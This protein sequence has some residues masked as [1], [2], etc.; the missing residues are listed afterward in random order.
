[1]SRYSV[2]RK[3]K[4]TFTDYKCKSCGEENP[5]NFYGRK[6]TECKN[7]F[8]RRSVER[9]QSHKNRAV[10]L[11]GGKCSNC[12]YNT[13]IGALEFHHTDPTK[14]DMTIAGSGKKWETIKKEV[15]K[16]ILLCANCHRELHYKLRICE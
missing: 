15:E 5:N 13:Y 14:K 6:K 9:R 1:M 7:C 3:G 16:C 4:Y 12:G 11:L 10:E 8:N 2:S